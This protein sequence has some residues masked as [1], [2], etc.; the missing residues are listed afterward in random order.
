LDWIMR[1]SSVSPHH[2]GDAHNKLGNVRS[3]PMSPNTLQ[4]RNKDIED[5][6]NWLYSKGRDE[7]LNI[8]MAC[9][10]R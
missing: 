4:Q 5:I 7:K 3:I 9:S 10:R 2:D 6:F 8:Q 1:K